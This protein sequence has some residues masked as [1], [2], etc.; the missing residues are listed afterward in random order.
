MLGIVVGMSDTPGE[1]TSEE[2]K[3]SSLFIAHSS[4]IT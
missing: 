2:S 3:N 1:T 4:F